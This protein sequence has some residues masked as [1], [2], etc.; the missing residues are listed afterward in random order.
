MQSQGPAGFG[1][2]GSDNEPMEA[3]SLEDGH[4]KEVDS[5]LELLGEMMTS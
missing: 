3:E 1:S 5:T 2:G 4:G